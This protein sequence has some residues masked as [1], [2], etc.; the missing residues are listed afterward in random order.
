MH[1]Y[2]HMYI[3]VLERL[4]KTITHLRS[5]ISIIL[6]ILKCKFARKSSQ[7]GVFVD[8]AFALPSGYIIGLHVHSRLFLLRATFTY[9]CLYE[10]TIGMQK[11]KYCALPLELYKITLTISCLAIKQV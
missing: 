3:M 6:L 8:L 11:S 2:L 5:Y 1:N 10:E 4:S 9:M 7:L